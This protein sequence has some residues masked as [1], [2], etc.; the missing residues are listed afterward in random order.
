MGLATFTK[1]FNTGKLDVKVKFP[2]YKKTFST[3]P[4]I[5][6]SDETLRDYFLVKVQTL[7]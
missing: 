1:S 7:R 6:K 5:P 2:F 3:F 4:K